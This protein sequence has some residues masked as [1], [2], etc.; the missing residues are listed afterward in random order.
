MNNKKKPPPNRTPLGVTHRR[1][2]HGRA[3]P[4]EGT[5][6]MAYGEPLIF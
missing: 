6:I 5:R 4:A 3:T 1:S 2:E